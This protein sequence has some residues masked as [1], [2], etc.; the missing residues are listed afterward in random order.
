M[1]F[2]HLL[3]VQIVNS[4]SCIHYQTWE[5][6]FICNNQIEQSFSNNGYFH[7]SVQECLSK[8]QNILATKSHW[9]SIITVCKLIPQEMALLHDF[10]YT[11]K[12]YF[13]PS[14]I[15]KQNFV[16][17]LARCLCNSVSQGCQYYSSYVL[18]SNL[19]IIKVGGVVVGK[20]V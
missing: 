2:I 7:F 5:F 13:L 14:L 6:S 19:T 8:W 17:S 12:T 18:Y 16:P 1:I 11:R 15:K 10:Y 4:Q 20:Q 9:S 3:D